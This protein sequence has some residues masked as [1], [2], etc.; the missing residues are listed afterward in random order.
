[1]MISNEFYDETWPELIHQV[2]ALVHSDNPS[3]VITGLLV[4][5]EIVKFYQWTPSNRR[6]ALNGI[7]DSLF[8]KLVATGTEA[9]KMLGNLNALFVLKTI[10]KTFNY[11][12]RMELINSLQQMDSI[13][14]WGSLFLTVIN[15]KWSLDVIELPANPLEREKHM[16][17][18]CK[19]WAYGCMNTLMGRY[20]R[21]R[22]KDKNYA[23]FSKVFLEQ[24]VPRTLDAY[25]I[26]I[27]NITNGEWVSKRVQQCLLTFLEHCVKP[28]QP[29]QVV[30]N[31][32]EPI[33]VKFIFPLLSYSDEDEEL[34]NE[35][36]VEYIH[37]KVDPPIDDFKSPI[38]AAHELLVVIAENRFADAFIPIITMINGI[39]T[40]L[41]QNQNPRMKFG[42]LNMMCYLAGLTLSEKSP[43][44]NQMEHFMVTFVFQEL[45]SPHAFLRA[46]ACDVIT[47]F[48]KLI[49]TE[50]QNLH[51]A[52]QNILNLISDNE[53]PVRVSA[54]LAIASFLKYP[55]VIQA[56][57][58]HVVQVMQGL[59]NT[60]NEIDL[61]TLTNSMELL[62]FEFSE[63][64]KPFATQLATQL[65]FPINHSETLS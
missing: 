8:P 56:M 20:A 13:V 32:L 1:M 10:L 43:V 46:K 30:R 48:A 61:D 19:K 57:K 38:T 52:F 14:A 49:Y 34:W 63:D 62:V 4:L 54:S 55:V 39:L 45:V 3:M 28:K 60:T 25:M 59:M 16:Y 24:F 41:N 40:N 47:R 26:Q 22:R 15:H 51:F 2:S 44:R 23:A 37:K 5:L 27:S 17:W 18:K 12:I 50:E 31:H 58:P 35:D 9:G 11:A 7:I 65:V 6:G 33:V 64:L 36:P 29:W 53:L 42:A 21:A